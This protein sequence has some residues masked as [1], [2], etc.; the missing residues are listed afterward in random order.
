MSDTHGYM[1]RRPCAPCVAVD[2]PGLAG[3]GHTV[4]MLQPALAGA[5]GWN[6]ISPPTIN[7][8]KYQRHT[9]ERI[10]DIYPLDGIWR[11][12]HYP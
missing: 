6:R 3:T 9:P 8:A 2:Q 1:S 5:L 4:A 7:Y 10:I 11:T 12:A